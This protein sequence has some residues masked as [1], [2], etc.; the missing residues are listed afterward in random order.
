MK[1]N[2]RFLFKVLFY[3]HCRCTGVAYEVH[4]SKF[5]GGKCE[6]FW[7]ILGF[8]TDKEYKVD[9]FEIDLKFCLEFRACS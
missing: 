3:F 2:G 4:F 1:K 7:R 8:W 9:Y 6:S 5:Y